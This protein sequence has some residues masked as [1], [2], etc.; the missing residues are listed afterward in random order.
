MSRGFSYW[1]VALLSVSGALA[2]SCSSFDVLNA[3]SSDGAYESYRGIEY[4]VLPRQH[5]D[6][7]RPV[8]RN[9]DTPLVV[10][11]YGGGWRNGSKDDYEFVAAALTDAGIAVAI[12][13]YR[14]HP[15]AE[16]PAFVEDGAAA[17]TWLLENAE[18]LGIDTHAVFLM[19]HSA[20]AHIAACIAFDASYLGAEGIRAAAIRGF[21]GLS[22]PY[23]FLPLEDGYLLEV[24]PE[25]LRER[26]QPIS[27]VSAEAPP[28]LLIH[29]KKD[30]TVRIENSRALARRMRELGVTVELKAYEGTGHA[31]VVAAIAP[32]LGFLGSTFEDVQ[33]FVNRVL[34]DIEDADTQ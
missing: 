34:N 5:L 25:E 26:S 16:F 2:S 24:F 12:P 19:G 23:D 15:D 8:A 6:F 33:S 29:G 21:I 22:G 3:L 13:D 30:A 11:Y 17:L 10:F 20:G 18:F 28:T 4:G 9:G 7:Y 31:K 32:P 14:L 27:L 1:R